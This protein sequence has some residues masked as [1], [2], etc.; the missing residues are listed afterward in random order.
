MYDT[1]TLTLIIIIIGWLYLG[2]WGGGL[3]MG[4]LS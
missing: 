1:K 4:L 3:S 2:G